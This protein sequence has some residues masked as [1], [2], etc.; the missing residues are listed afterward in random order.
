[1]SRQ[2]ECQVHWTNCVIFFPMKCMQ[3]FHVRSNGKMISTFGDLATSVK[4]F[5]H[6]IWKHKICLQEGLP[7]KYYHLG[8]CVFTHTISYMCIMV[9]FQ[10]TTSTLL[11][12]SYPYCIDAAN[13]SSFSGFKKAHL[14]AEVG[15]DGL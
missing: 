3:L 12:V 13:T 9:A 8:S 10:G 5:S 4:N 1:M 15:C 6:I 2:A 14:V 7:D 11:Y